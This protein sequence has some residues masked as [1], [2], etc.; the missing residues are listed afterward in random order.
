MICSNCQKESSRHKYLDGNWY[1]HKCLDLS[2]AGGMKIDGSLTRMRVRDQSLKYEGDFV[3]PHIWDKAT[4]RLI[5]NESYV[6]MYGNGGDV[7]SKE[8]LKNYPKLK[9]EK[10]KDDNVTFSGVGQEGERI[11][12]I[13]K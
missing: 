4:K 1:C 7:Y 11:K 5:V 3:T 9:P 2:E 6:K 8:E 12:E 10:K 13:V